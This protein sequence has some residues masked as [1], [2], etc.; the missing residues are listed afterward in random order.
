M[1]GEGQRE[2]S[3]RHAGPAVELSEADQANHERVK[4]LEAQ[5]AEAQRQV[6]YLLKAL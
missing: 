2:G 4:V 3:E 6:G 1:Q 5:L